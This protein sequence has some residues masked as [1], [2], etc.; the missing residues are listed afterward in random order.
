MPISVENNFITGNTSPNKSEYQT[1][2]PWQ[3]ESGVSRWKVDNIGFTHII[4]GYKV[5]LQTQIEIETDSLYQ[6]WQAEQNAEQSKAQ[7]KTD[8]GSLPAWVLNGDLSQAEAY[9]EANV[10]DLASAKDVLKRVARVLV[11]MRDYL[12]IKG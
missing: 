9:I 2:K 12:R 11:L 8:F 10:T 5:R 6:S 1:F 3:H 7:A 4:E